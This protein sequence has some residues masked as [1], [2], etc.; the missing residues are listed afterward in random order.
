MGVPPQ[1]ATQRRNSFDL[2]LRY[3]FLRLPRNTVAVSVSLFQTQTATVAQHRC[4]GVALPPAQPRFEF[5]YC[6]EFDCVPPK[7]ETKRR[8]SFDLAFRFGFYAQPETPVSQRRFAFQAQTETV[9]K[10]RFGGVSLSKFP[11]PQRAT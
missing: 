3:G 9:L 8:N 2:A 11:Y 5:L 4:G 1:R 10:R 6:L 7:R